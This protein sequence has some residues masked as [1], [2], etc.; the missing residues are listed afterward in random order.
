[1]NHHPEV[2]YVT[3]RAFFAPGGHGGLVRTEAHGAVHQFLTNAPADA[4]GYVRADLIIDLAAKM[5]AAQK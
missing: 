5:K 4:V 3:K 2:I 1:M